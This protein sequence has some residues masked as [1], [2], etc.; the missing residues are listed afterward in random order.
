MGQIVFRV[1][2]DKIG[3]T[4]GIVPIGKRCFS[5]GRDA[6]SLLGGVDSGFASGQA[7]KTL[8]KKIQ[9]GAQYFWGVSCRIRGDK[10]QLDLISEIRGH[11]LKG[12]T[13]IGHVE[14]TLIG[15]TGISEKEERDVSLGLLPEIKRSTGGIR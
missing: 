3:V 1:G 7:D 9:P 2:E 13:D 5:G 14:R 6:R 11:F 4:D 15:A 12:H 8:I 10:D